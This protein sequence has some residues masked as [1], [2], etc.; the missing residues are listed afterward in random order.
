LPSSW[1]E[2]DFVIHDAAEP[3]LAPQVVLRRFHRNEPQQKLHLLQ[4]AARTQ[5]AG[6]ADGKR[7][8]GPGGSAPAAGTAWHTSF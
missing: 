8:I 1:L 5:R 4:L 6:I 3:L 2:S 7:V